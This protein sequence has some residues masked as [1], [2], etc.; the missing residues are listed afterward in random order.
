[1]MYF[2]LRVSYRRRR[3]ATTNLTAGESEWVPTSN[4]D[5][6]RGN[7]VSESDRTVII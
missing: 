3:E 1:M 6:A 7:P 4:V 2:T 5:I